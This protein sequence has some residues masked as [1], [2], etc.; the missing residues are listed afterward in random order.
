MR[1]QVGLCA[2]YENRWA[3][4]GFSGRK[5]VCEHQHIEMEWVMDK[6]VALLAVATLI[7]LDYCKA[8]FK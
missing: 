1:S 3:T 6:I 5:V 7:T 4:R 2:M 8:Y